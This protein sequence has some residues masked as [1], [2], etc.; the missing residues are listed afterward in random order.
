M[1]VFFLASSAVAAA[2]IAVACT[3]DPEREGFAPPDGGGGGANLPEAAPPVDAGPEPD[4][5]PPFDPKDEPVTCAGAPCAKDLVAGDEHFCALLEGGTVKCWGADTLA[6]LTGVTQISAAGKSTCVRFDDGGVSCWG[7]NDKGQ[8]GLASDAGTPVFDEDPHP[9]PAPVALGKLGAAVRVDVGHGSACAVLASGKVACWGHDHRSQLSRVPFDPYELEPYRVPG[10]AGIDPLVVARAVPGAATS[11]ALTPNGEVWSW[12][13]LAGD[14]G[15]VSG[16][17]S[18]VSPSREPAR[19]ASLAKVSSLAVSGTIQPPPPDEP[20]P[21]PEPP[22]PRAHACAIADGQVHCWGQSQVGALC[23]GLPDKQQVPRFA[24]IASKHWPQ[25]IAVADE[26]TCVRMTDG[27]VQCCGKGASGQ[28]GNGSASLYSAFFVP[29]TEL[30]SHAVK[31]AT[32][33]AS[34]CALVQG[35]TVECWGSNEHGELGKKPDADPHPSPVKI[36]F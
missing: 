1:K 13:A 3:D 2:A 7:R 11:I 30:K 6:G 26:L 34:V 17:V 24:P 36:A 33:N 20:G 22:P 19:I 15:V 5:R 14:D 12:G 4:A 29:A 23:T 21:V 10:L 16:R 32:S 18:S 8:L 25:Q 31:V 9:Q 27:E 35:G 28:L